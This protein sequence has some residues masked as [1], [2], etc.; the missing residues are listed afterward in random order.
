MRTLRK[1]QGPAFT[2]IELLVVI[3]IIGILAGLL[4]PTISR[5]RER[6]RQARCIA[7]VKQIVS[8]ILLYATDYQNRLMLPP[9]TNYMAVG[10]AGTASVAAENRPLYPY[11]KDFDVFECPSDRGSSWT[12]AAGNHC[13]T[14]KG[15]SYAYPVGNV[16]GI[17]VCAG[18]KM[19][20]TNFSYSSKKVVIFEPPIATTT[21][22]S[23]DQWHSPRQVSV[24]GFLDG[25]SEL[26]FTNETTIDPEGHTYY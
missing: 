5:T 17:M 7:N 15:S 26:V 11:I 9:G 12:E 23:K 6:G 3:A 19:T 16:G 8:G 13:F 24:L 4:L 25:H 14:E 1:R 22:G 2:L 21:F 18:R 10:G 20:S